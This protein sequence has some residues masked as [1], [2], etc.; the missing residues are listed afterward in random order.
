MSAN[1]IDAIIS[2]LRGFLLAAATTLIGMLIIASLTVFIRISD[3]TVSLLNQLIKIL[4]IVLGTWSAVG[5]GGSHGFVTG[6]VIALFYM[7]TGY[8][9]YVAL[10][11][12]VWSAAGML[13]EMLFGSAV[14]GVCG[15]VF[16]NLPPKSRRRKSAR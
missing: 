1:R 14:G 15:A 8:S 10:G 4:A 12:G 16:A 9:L 6:V 7:I 3:G 5:R 11:G 2:V 13:G